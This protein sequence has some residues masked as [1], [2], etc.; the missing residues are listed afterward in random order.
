[1]NDSKN[2]VDSC[3][4]LIDKNQQSNDKRRAS[5]LR[6]AN[7]K[8]KIKKLNDDGNLKNQ[9]F[10]SPVK[11]YHTEKFESTICPN[12]IDANVNCNEINNSNAETSEIFHSQIFD[13][14][15]NCIADIFDE[16]E[17]NKKATRLNLD[18][19]FKSSYLAHAA[20]MMDTIFN[21]DSKDDSS[22][23]DSGEDENDDTC[24]AELQIPKLDD[25]N[26]MRD[27]NRTINT[28]IFNIKESNNRNVSHLYNVSTISSNFS[29]G[30]YKYNQLFNIIIFIQKLSLKN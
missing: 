20:D 9:L 18:E 19:I 13:S 25:F 22:E 10:E 4:L 28:L 16:K 15:T 3:K 30:N 12:I 26:L 5:F 27:I 6:S 8:K 1:M 2:V 11:I 24:I 21:N 29:S 7:N 14:E 23:S 17:I